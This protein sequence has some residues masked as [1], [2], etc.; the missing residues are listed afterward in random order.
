MPP[1]QAFM[2]ELVLIAL[3]AL[4]PTDISQDVS[5]N[6]FLQIAQVTALTSPEFFRHFRSSAHRFRL[7]HLFR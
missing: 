2:L 5:A 1:I 4:L 3:E 7:L 6:M